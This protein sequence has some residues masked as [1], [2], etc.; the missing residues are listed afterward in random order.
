MVTKSASDWIYPAP[1]SGAE[2]INNRPASNLGEVVWLSPRT[3]QG[4]TAGDENGAMRQV[5]VKKSAIVDQIPV[6]WVE[7]RV[8][9]E[10][11]QLAVW[12]PGLTMTKESTLPFLQRLAYAGFVAVSLDPWQHGERGSETG[13]EIGRRVFGNFR[14]YMW[15]ILGHT[16]LDSMRIVDW[17]IE[18]FDVEPNVVAGGLSMGGDI[19]VAL[20]GIDRRVARVAAIV[21]TPDW[22]RPGM[23]RLT[24]RGRFLPQGKADP[25]GQWFFDQLNPITHLGRYSHGP[26]ID[27][28]C[29]AEDTHVPPDGAIRFQTEMEASYPRA[30]KSVRVTL[31]PGL[32]HI[33]AGGDRRV[34][35]NCL[36]WLRSTS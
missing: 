17:A 4:D 15:P 5:E 7:P 36:D 18:K 28:E 23:C 11:A 8:G 26:A 9:R 30:A 24:E 2:C 1:P 14:R 29:G 6:V 22:T 16:T 31:H 33:T 20:A 10:K 21:A 13:Q 27:F 32:G 3:R 35:Q 34:A 19:A 12:L 25:Y